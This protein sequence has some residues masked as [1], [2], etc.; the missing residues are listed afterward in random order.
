MAHVT[1]FLGALQLSYQRTKVP[2]EKSHVFYNILKETHNPFSPRPLTLMTSFHCEHLDF[3]PEKVISKSAPS[4]QD[5]QALKLCH[6]H[7]PSATRGTKHHFV[8]DPTKR[9]VG[10]P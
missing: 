1:H 5:S 4:F 8:E 2:K 3:S 6:Y 10:F 7:F 9:A